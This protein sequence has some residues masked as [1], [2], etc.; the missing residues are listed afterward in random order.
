[1]HRRF[2]LMNGKSTRASGS[3]NNAFDDDKGSDS[4]STLNAQDGV[5]TA[6]SL[7]IKRVDH[8][9]S[10]W[11]KS[12]K[13]RNTSS[14]TLVETPPILNRSENDPWRDFLFV[15]ITFKFVIKSEYILKACKD[16]IQYWPGISWNSDPLELHP[17]ILLTFLDE[18]IEYRDG[19]AEKKD[20]SDLD[21]YVLSSL[22]VLL[23]SIH[24]DYENT[25]TFIKRLRAHREITYDELY[26]IFVPRTI[27]VARCAVT[28][29]PRLFKLVSW[30]QASVEG[31]PHFQLNVEAIDLVDKTVT[32]SVAVGKVQ[33]T[34]LIREFE[35]TIPIDTLDV[36]PLKYHT[37]PALLRDTIIKRGKKWVDMIGVHHKQYDGVAG[38][39]KD[40]RLIRHSVTG[41]IMVDRV[42]FHRKNPNYQFPVPVVEGIEC[43]PNMPMQFDDYGGP[44]PPSPPLPPLPTRLPPPNGDNSTAENNPEL[45][46][47]ELLLTPTVVYGF[48]LSD[49]LWLEFNVD[50]VTDVQWND[51]AFANLVLP[52][53]RKLMLKSLVEA[54]HRDTFDDFIKGKGHGLVINLFGPTGVGKTFSAEATSEHVRRP[55]Y[56][57]GAGDLGT[58]PSRMDIILER[59]FDM[60]T[61]WKAIV[62]I[63]EADVFME[64]R[65]LHDLER[66]A[67]VAVFLRHVEYYRG[68]LFLTT[69]RVKAFDEAFLS[70]IHVA[71][72]FHELPF[73]SRIEVWTAF[74][75][76]VGATDIVTPEQIRTLAQRDINGRQI[77][78]AAKTA[79]SLAL[80]KGEKLSFEHFV[81]TLDAMDG[82]TKEFER[83]RAQGEEEN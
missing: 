1:M 57:V 79:Q 41:R 31:R 7:K 38:F 73:Q 13:Y 61:T 75:K 21:K 72:H 22:N 27:L 23:D 66:N 76:K 5:L 36:Y 80:G 50:K 74:I 37:E 83:L 77:K 14:R 44:L 24:K 48:S 81:S 20:K 15:Y 9:Y 64:Q 33:A 45:T 28:H 71:L 49:K 30:N 54:H 18:F 12:W 4:A 35:G 26:A 65:S 58:D 6:P 70:R 2:S 11:S 59:I 68:I 51:E 17:E 40:N 52:A 29:L 8:Y 10:K 82:F 39:K 32:Q 55:L 62:L 78:N 53:D 56:I 42:N 46:E 60:A 63:D 19:L 25:I 43:E 16:V 47:E 3:L 69:N 67:M 34:I